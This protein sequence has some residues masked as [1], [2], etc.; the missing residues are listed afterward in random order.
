M[1]GAL[2]K[3]GKN[4]HNIGSQ[5]GVLSPLFLDMVNGVFLSISSEVLDQPK[6]HQGSPLIQAKKHM[7][8][9]QRRI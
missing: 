9:K 8:S 2:H 3:S 4:V 1:A 5:Q 7:K 6:V